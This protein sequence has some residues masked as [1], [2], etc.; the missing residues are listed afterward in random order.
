TVAVRRDRRLAGDPV[1]LAALS[2]AI[3][4]GVQLSASYVTF[5]YLAWIFPPVAVALLGRRACA[6]ASSS[7]Q[8]A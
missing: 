3:L 2:A 4:I 6:A 8:S 7:S 1:R 5:A